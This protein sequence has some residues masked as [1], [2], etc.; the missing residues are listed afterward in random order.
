MPRSPAPPFA[1]RS[2]GSV[3]GP[4]ETRQRPPSGKRVGTVGRDARARDN[5]HRTGVRIEG[6][7][8]AV[9]IDHVNDVVDVREAVHAPE[10][11]AAED[12]GNSRVDIELDQA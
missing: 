1:F 7:D 9:A 5:P 10:A 3:T 4:T 6:A 8:L 12:G 2:C 11:V